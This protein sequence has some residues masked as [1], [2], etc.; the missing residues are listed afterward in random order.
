M[1]RLMALMEGRRLARPVDDVHEHVMQWDTERSKPVLMAHDLLQ[2]RIVHLD[3]SRPD[4]KKQLLKLA[5][6]TEKL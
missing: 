4:G 1:G 6:T 5:P 3:R 2:V